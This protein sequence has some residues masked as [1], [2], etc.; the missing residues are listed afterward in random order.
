MINTLMGMR[1]SQGVPADRLYD[2]RTD[3]RRRENRENH[4]TVLL[5]RMDDL[6]NCARVLEWSSVRGITKKAERT[7]AKMT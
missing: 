6:R 1:H 4:L 2:L 7:E 3:R 5:N